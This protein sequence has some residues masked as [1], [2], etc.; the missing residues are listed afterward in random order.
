[1]LK[2]FIIKFWPQI[3]IFIVV[4]A[5]FSRLFFPP[6]IFITPDFGRSDLVHFNI[7][8]KMILAEA[9]KN[10]ELPLW[11]PRIGQGFPVFEEGQI[12]FF[13]IPNLILFGLFPF[14]LA[15]NLGYIVTFSLAAL[16]TYL[17]SRSLRLNKYAS[18]LAALTFAFSTI[19]VLR[20]HHYN[21]IQTAS[22]MPWILWLINSF[23]ST[24]KLI[25]FAFIP[26]VLSQQIFT[27][28]PQ[29]TFYSLLICGFFFL[30]K[31]F[32]Q[33]KTTKLK[34]KLII[35]FLLFILLGFFIASV[36]LLSTWQISSN[37]GG[38]ARFSPQKIL[39]DF[40]LNPI[41]LLKVFNPY[42]L[43]NPK[44]GSYPTWQ[45]G[46]WGVFWENN[47][48][49][50]V[51]QLILISSLLIS[52]FFTKTNKLLKNSIFLWVSLGSLGVFLALGTNGPL[53]PIFSIPPFS[54]FR[55][56]AR[57]LFFTSF[58][59]SILAGY[60]LQKITGFKKRIFHK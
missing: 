36:Q 20:L 18:V 28:F 6:S 32:S 2:K 7:P 8:V 25:Y 59:A 37:S 27:G 29:L 40:P 30:V 52:L 21:F 33:I 41:N 13:Y 23:F 35:I 47:A 44:Y 54:F 49:F 58:S 26:V 22:L 48:Y 17:F 43:G 4:F 34:I 45:P 19:F 15:F 16:G 11:E 38:L 1:M 56:P 50:G 14:W 39:K 5:F 31:L 3:L 9:I 53:H 12:G 60:G 51:I 46:R 55:V 42:I 10:R 57:F 24:K